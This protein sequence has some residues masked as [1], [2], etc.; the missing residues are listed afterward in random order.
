MTEGERLAK[1]FATSAVAEHEKA[2]NLIVRPDPS[3]RDTQC[4]SVEAQSKWVSDRRMALRSAV[5]DLLVVPLSIHSDMDWLEYQAFSGSYLRYNYSGPVPT[6]ELIPMMS[7]SVS[8]RYEQVS[9]VE[10]PFSHPDFYRA[11]GESS[12][13]KDLWSLVYRH[14]PVQWVPLEVEAYMDVL[15]HTVRVQSHEDYLRAGTQLRMLL[16]LFPLETSYLCLRQIQWI[17]DFIS[18]AFSSSCAVLNE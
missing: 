18:Y 3:P 6:V 2:R 8:P 1:F 7:S 13:I 16:P 5:A 17:K 4:L 14:D 12:S 15:T 11:L 9:H 10:R